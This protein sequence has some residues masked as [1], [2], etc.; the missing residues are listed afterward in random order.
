M[1]SLVPVEDILANPFTGFGSLGEDEVIVLGR[2]RD[3]IILQDAAD[4]RT[5]D[6]QDPVE[7]MN[8][9]KQV[10]ERLEQLEKDVLNGKATFDTYRVNSPISRNGGGENQRNRINVGVNRFSSGSLADSI[11][12]K[13]AKLISGFGTEEAKKSVDGDFRKPTSNLQH[14]IDRGQPISWLLNE[15]IDPKLG[16]AIG[17]L[18]DSLL[19]NEYFRKAFESDDIRPYSVGKIAKDKDSD[20]E[21]IFVVGFLKIHDALSSYPW[22]TTRDRD[23]IGT[24]LLQRA[25]IIATRALWA[26]REARRL[27][28]TVDELIEKMLAD[29]S[30]LSI[31]DPDKDFSDS[32]IIGSMMRGPSGS[33]RVFVA[34]PE[35]AVLGLVNQSG[36]ERRI[37]SQFETGYSN[38]AYDTSSRAAQEVAMFGYHPAMKPELRPIYGVAA[39]G[40]ISERLAESVSQYGEYL[41]VLKQKVVDRTTITEGDS[42]STMGSSSYMRKPGLGMRA[43]NDQSD[44]DD[45]FGYI[46]AQIHSDSKNT[47][48]SLDDVAYV[49]IN[50]VTNPETREKFDPESP[51]YESDNETLRGLR[52]AGIEIK[53]LSDELYSGYV[54]DIDGF[55][56]TDDSDVRG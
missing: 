53:F 52:E 54:S 21:I 31:Y 51:D 22:L 46:E 47:G 49:L 56:Y 44:Y 12:N 20:L 24:G 55:E 38:G 6:I 7:R 16:E 14:A 25:G 36:S 2:T 4:S 42:L 39:H 27:Q 3:S 40:G 19:S 10:A 29:T 17:S 37:K 50:D 23:I 18:V 48:V 45:T 13:T 32:K 35:S 28:I 5:R 30:S 15:S 41:V 34:L 9:E 26:E 33:D 1:M 8:R 11:S 43:M